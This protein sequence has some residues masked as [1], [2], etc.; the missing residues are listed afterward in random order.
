M[1]YVYGYHFF[2]PVNFSF[3]VAKGEMK[4]VVLVKANIK[5]VRL[6]SELNFKAFTALVLWCALIMQKYLH[7]SQDSLKF[8]ELCKNFPENIFN[9]FASL[10]AK[11]RSLITPLH[12]I[13]SFISAKM[14][15]SL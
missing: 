9:E 13:C 6:R 11:N 1:A 12:S 5:V 10:G 7:Y 4:G 8:K 14:L 15:G 2:N 3:G